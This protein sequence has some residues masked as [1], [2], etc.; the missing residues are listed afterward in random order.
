MR[1][2]RLYDTPNAH[3]C[4][5]SVNFGGAFNAGFDTFSE[6]RSANYERDFESIQP[7]PLTLCTRGVCLDPPAGETIL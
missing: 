7:L 5:Y 3:V 6:R 4:Q 1:F 2:S